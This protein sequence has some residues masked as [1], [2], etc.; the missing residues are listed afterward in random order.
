LNSRAARAD[1]LQLAQIAS[2]YRSRESFLTEPSLDPPNATS[3]QAGAPLPDED[4]LILSTNHSAKGQEWQFVFLLKTVDGRLP[5]DLLA[6]RRKSRRNA[7][8]FT[9]P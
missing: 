1:L 9:S 2:T 7:A 5:S 4:Y 8:C 3:D 6:Q